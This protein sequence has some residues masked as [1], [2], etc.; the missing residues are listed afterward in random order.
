MPEKAC[1]KNVGTREKIFFMTFPRLVGK[2]GVESAIGKIKE[3]EGFLR[4]CID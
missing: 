3:I 2:V 4:L 1:S